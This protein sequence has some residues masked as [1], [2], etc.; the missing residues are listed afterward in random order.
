M[1]FFQSS[2]CD[3]QMRLGSP[4]GAV[5]NAPLMPVASPST[6]AVRLTPRSLQNGG[7]AAFSAA[8]FSATVAAV[9]AASPAVVVRLVE[10]A[11]SARSVASPIGTLAPL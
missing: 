3:R 1:T 8:T 9:L 2:Q 11:A 6:S 10:A 4:V 5:L 7:V